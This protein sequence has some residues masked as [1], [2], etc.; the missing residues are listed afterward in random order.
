MIATLEGKITATEQASIIVSVNGIGYRVYLMKDALLSC[1]EGKDIFLWIY[2]AVREN[3]EELFGFLEKKEYEF[4][5]LLTSISGVGPRTALNI[6]TIAPPQTLQK[7]ITSGNSSYL[8]KVS[9]IGKKSAEKIV[10][11]LSDKIKNVQNEEEGSSLE[12]DA[13]AVLG[14]Q[15]LGYSPHDARG[16]LKNVP[17]DITGASERIKEALKF[18]GK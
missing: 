7:A 8:T 3:D 13:D 5:E 17:D 9:G 4:F 14:L 1:T 10:L 15:S 16:A 2:H 18:L 6:L 12:E 11:E